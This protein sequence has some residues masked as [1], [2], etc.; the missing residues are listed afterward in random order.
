MVSKRRK[1]RF[2]KM[3]KLLGI[4]QSKLRTY[5]NGN[6]FNYL[7]DDHLILTGG[8]V[9]ANFVGSEYLFSIFWR[10]EY[11]FP[12]PASPTTPFPPNQMVVSLVH[13]ALNVNMTCE[14]TPSI[15]PFR[16]IHPLVLFSKSK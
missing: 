7:G 13:I 14:A 12:K 8:G 16:L 4:T 2:G 1:F 10:T 9:L 5:G 6:H 3:Y 11:L 15:F